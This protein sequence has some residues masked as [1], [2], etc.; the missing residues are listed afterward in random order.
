MK[1]I[2]FVAPNLHSGGAEAV[3]V[4]I[5]NHFKISNFTIKLVLLKKEG[6][7]LTKLSSNI[8][9]IDL[10]EK[11]TL[12]S[13]WKLYK[14]IKNEKPD[15][16]FS[17]IGQVNLALAFLKTI[18]FR[19][20]K[21]IGRENV[22]YSEWLFK[23]KN[24]KKNIMY[25]LYKLFLNKLDIIVV[26]S[27]FMK[28]EVMDYFKIESAKISILSNPVETKEINQL[29]NE[30]IENEKWNDQK[31][32]L[33]A[34]GRLEKVKNYN[35]M[36]NVISKLPDDFHLNIFG[37]GKEEKEIKKY[38]SAKGLDGKVTLHGY[39]ENPYKYLKSSFGLLLTS[40]RESF[41]NVVLEANACGTYTFSYEMP[42]GI[43]EITEHGVNG[44]IIQNENFILMAEEIKRKQNEGYSRSSI[45][46]YT[47]KH[48]IENYMDK[49][50]K[51]FNV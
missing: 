33:V 9:I 46:E 31:I 47:N 5:L 50:N 49:L 21:F 20:I 2:L 19:K 6:N 1:K 12:Y 7:H 27:E 40:Q 23:D 25:Y 28:K 44:S 30:K 26:Q 3:L 43:K 34:V 35:E 8:E 51:L 10:N 41:P 15:Y 14:V 16:V 48:S 38:I 32:N 13:L 17:I 45:I 11:R 39:V 22:V 18:F 24:L 37:E 36:I 29:S 42:G 4:K